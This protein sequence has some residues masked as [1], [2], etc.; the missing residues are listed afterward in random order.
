MIIIKIGHVF[1]QSLKGGH[2]RDGAFAVADDNWPANMTAP[3]PATPVF[4]NTNLQS[5]LLL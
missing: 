5:L 1:G 3:F 2:S 4:A